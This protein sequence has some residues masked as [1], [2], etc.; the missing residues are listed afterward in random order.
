[1]ERSNW[2]IQGHILLEETTPIAVYPDEAR[3][4]Q[5]FDL[6]RRN[7]LG[8]RYTV[9]SPNGYCT[10]INT[11]KDVEINKQLKELNNDK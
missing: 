4:A 2:P 8:V 11:E 1:M 7:N 10:G 3:S 5:A 6:Y 9:L